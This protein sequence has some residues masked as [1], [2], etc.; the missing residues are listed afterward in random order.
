MAA[1]KPGYMKALVREKDE[2]AFGQRDICFWQL[3]VLG[4]RPAQ[5]ADIFVPN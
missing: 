5:G 4:G 1:G 3:I 2:G